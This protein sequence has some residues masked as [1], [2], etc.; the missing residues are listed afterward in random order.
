MLKTL[1]LVPAKILDYNVRNLRI[2]NIFA[3][4]LNFAEPFLKKEYLS[5]VDLM[6][7][8]TI[9]YNSNHNRKCNIL[10]FL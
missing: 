5:I 7:I 4:T 8:A 1:Y 3:E 6:G 9:C 2:A 10:T